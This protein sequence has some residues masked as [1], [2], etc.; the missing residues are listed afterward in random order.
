MKFGFEH[1]YAQDL[2]DYHLPGRPDVVPAPHLLFWNAPLAQQLGLGSIVERDADLAEV[3]SGNK[4]PDDALPIAQAYAGHQFG[5]FSRQL[6]DGRALLLGELRDQAGQRFDV[7]LKGSG[8]TD[9]SRG[10]D[11]KAAVG[12]MLREVLIGEFLHAVGIPTT[13]ALAVV[14]TGEEVRRSV[15]LPGAVLTRVASS[16]IRVGTFEFYAA[17]GDVTRVKLL[18]DYAIAR[19]DPERVGRDDRYVEFL[20]AVARRQT[21]LVAKWMNIGFIHGVMN[22]DNV[23]VSGESID[24][25]PCAFLESYD[26][27]TVFSSIDHGGRY[28][29]GN[30]PAIAQ[31]NLAR[32]C[33]AMIPFLDP[34]P[35]K[36][37]ALATEIVEAFPE[38]IRARMSESRLSKLG[39]SS[40]STIAVESD[41]R[42]L[43]DGWLGLLQA[44]R[45]DFTLAWRRLADAAEGNEAS[46]VSMFGDRGALSTWLGRWRERCAQDDAGFAGAPQ[47]LGRI[48]ALRMRAV[49]P[50]VVPR[51]HL[52]EEALGAA[53]DKDDLRPFEALLEALRSPF[54]SAWEDSRYAIGASA[55]ATARY[56]TFCG[57]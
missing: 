9:F 52:V 16:H 41:D 53:S 18:A 57:T 6:G 33:E 34:A 54:D 4:L 7:S 35:A 48:R 32:L 49:N 12:P 8:P 27:A 42:I 31:W 5:N 25:G 11:G 28:A 45:V 21:D 37:L 39:L 20:R 13:R 26:P 2:P 46:L 50:S 30:Q 55:E 38:R 22:T 23:A 29:Y 17:R 44:D 24:F 14:A 3:F 1:T 10:G 43:L 56:R 51:N 36:A 19:H 40:S 15:M 47:E